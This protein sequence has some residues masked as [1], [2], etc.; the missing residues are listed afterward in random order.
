MSGKLGS[1]RVIAFMA[2][3]MWNLF[4]EPG[5]NNGRPA[6]Q[7]CYSG[8]RYSALLRVWGDGLALAA[9]NASAQPQQQPRGRRQLSNPRCDSSP[10]S[11]ILEF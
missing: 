10:R 11:R 5:D 9:V 1:A 3:N 7:R 4:V 2:K 8:Q 6:G